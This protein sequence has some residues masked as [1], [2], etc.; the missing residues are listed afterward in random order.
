MVVMTSHDQLDV[1]NMLEIINSWWINF[2]RFI[3]TKI[4]LR[5]Y[6]SIILLKFRMK[7]QSSCGSSSMRQIYAAE[8]GTIE[9]GRT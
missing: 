4:F 9:S 5:E 3:A 6:I 1:C 7:R 2:F 8:D